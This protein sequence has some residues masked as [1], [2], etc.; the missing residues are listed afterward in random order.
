MDER[1]LPFWGRISVIESPL[2]EEETTSGIVLPAGA[3]AGEKDDG[4]PARRGIVQAIDAEIFRED[5]NERNCADRLS[6]G[7]VVYF[8][9]PKRLR[10]DLLAVDLSDILAY[11]PA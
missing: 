2:D 10:G 11:E 9:N 7:T 5:S 4:E 8:R 1:A 3:L 6:P